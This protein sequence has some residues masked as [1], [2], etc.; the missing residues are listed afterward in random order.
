MPSYVRNLFNTQRRSPT[1]ASST[2]RFR[3]PASWKRRSQAKG[4]KLTHLIGPGV[5]HKYE[6]KTLKELLGRLE[7]IV[8]QRPR[9]AAQRG[10]LANADAELQRGG[11]GDG[12]DALEEHWQDSRVDA[13]DRQPR[14]SQ[15]TTKNVTGLWLNLD[16]ESIK[17]VTIDGQELNV[18][19][20][21]TKGAGHHLAP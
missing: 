17:R 11:L 6:P 13:R 12:A 1:A 14:R 16:D 3:R 9:K 8:G 5:E 10:S 18:H 20:G 4:R 7:A 15:V 19:R 2:S 21:G